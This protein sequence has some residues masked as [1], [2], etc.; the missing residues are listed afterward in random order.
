MI[1]LLDLDGVMVQAKNWE[2]PK[3]LEDG[4]FAFTERSIEALQK[5]IT[6]DTTVVI[7]SSHKSRYTIDEWIRIFDKR[8]LRISKLVKL[9]DSIEKYINRKEE[10]LNWFANKI[11][12]EDFVIID[13][14]KSLNA[15]PLNLKSKLI[16]TSSFIGLTSE[17]LQEYNSS[18]MQLEIA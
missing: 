4:F 6:E 15:L 3:I 17:L 8:G 12:T 7:T 11:T 14:D 5:L 18:S 2:T 1:I 9:N 16:L 10:I 13:D